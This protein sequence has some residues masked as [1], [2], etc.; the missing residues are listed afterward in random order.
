MRIEYPKVRIMALT[1][2]APP[3]AV[4]DVIDRL[5]MPNCLRLTES[6]NRTNLNY[7]VRQKWKGAVLADVVEFIR[8]N[9]NGQTGII[10]ATSRKKCEHIAAE[11]RNAHHLSAF[12]YHGTMD[13]NEITHR[14]LTNFA[15]CSAQNAFGMGINKS[16]GMAF[17][18]DLRRMCLTTW[19]AVRFVIHH[20]L[21]KDLENYY[22]EAGRAGGDSSPAD[23]VLSHSY[24]DYRAGCADVPRRTR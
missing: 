13:K 22:Q 5:G 2:T 14:R 21:P 19:E 11:L 24:R 10:Y 23:C 6:H 8:T 7:V 12:P 4:N 3:E 1:G 17:S 16:N 20:S 15:K 9:Y 18:H